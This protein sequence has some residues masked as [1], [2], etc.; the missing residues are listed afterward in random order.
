MAHRS[1]HRKFNPTE[2]WANKPYC[3][4]CK[5]KKV[6]YGQICGECEK[7]GGFNENATEINIGELN[8]KDLVAQFTAE[9]QER[10]EASERVVSLVGY[11]KDCAQAIMRSVALTDVTAGEISFIPLKPNALEQLANGQ[12][13]IKGKE[14]LDILY[15]V[16]AQASEFEVILGTLFVKGFKGNGNRT[17]KV[18]APLLYLK[19]DLEKTESDT[20]VFSLKED[21]TV[22]LNQSLIA[23][24]ASAEN[25]E[26]LEVRFQDLYSAVPEWPLTF[27]NVQK[28]FQGLN[29]YFPEIF[30]E[31]GTP[32][33]FIEFD[34]IEAEREGYK[35]CPA[36]C[37]ILAP[38]QEGEGT[39]VEEL[40]NIL[41][42]AKDKTALDFLLL[43][44]APTG[45]NP[46]SVIED[47]TRDGFTETVPAEDANWHSLFPFDL[48][49]TQKKIV[50][51][52][53][54]NNLTVVSG[55]PGTG[56]SYTIAAII[57]DHLL[58]GK[59]VLFVSRMDKAV[60][61]V[62]AWLEEFI[63][64]YSIARSGARK[65]QRALA[66]KLDTITS[67]NSPVIPYNKKQIDDATKEHEIAQ[68]KLTELEEEF[69]EAITNERS[70]TAV[71]DKVNDINARL[72]IE[73]KSDGLSI[74]KAKASRLKEKIK[75]ADALIRNKGFFIQT[76]WGEQ[77]IKSIRS[78]LGV[79]ENTTA[80]DLILMAE[81][82]EN[83]RVREEVEVEIAKFDAVD[84]IW[85]EIQ[86]LKIQLRKL[87]LDNLKARLLG[88]LHL[89]VHN[90]EKRVELKKFVK[91][92]R[93]ANIREKLAL[94][95][96]VKTDTLLAAFPCWASTTYHLS[97]ILPV[98]PGMFDLVIFDEAS[99]CD[100]ASAVP[101][102]YRANRVLIV[103]DPKQLNHVVFLGK[104]AEYSSFAKNKVPPDI[105]ANYRF[106]TNSLFDVAEN[107]VPQA[108][109]FMLDE[110]FRSDPHII[111]FSNK[112]FYKE[113]IRIMTHRPKMGLA[114]QETAIQLDYVKG[115]RTE[116]AANPL[117]IEAIFKHAKQ[118]IAQSPSE[119]PTTIGILSPF[120]DQVNAIT[121]AL[122][123]YLSLT[124]VERHKIVVGTAHSLQGDEK[125]VVILSL[126]L[127]PKFHHGTLNFL[128]KPNVF[129]VSITRAKKKLI[130][131]SSVTPEDLPNGLLKEF[132]LHAVRSTVNEIP[133]S[134]FDSKF[135]EQ[136]AQAL[137][138]SGMKVWPQYQAAG[139]YIDLVVGDGKNWVAV[140]C[141]GP[142]HFNME[143][144][145]NFYDVWRQGILER[146][147]WRFIRISNRDW[148]RDSDGQIQKIKQVLDTLNI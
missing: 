148:E 53:R 131:V 34:A 56:K 9:E 89:I 67:P 107:L 146:A 2:Y 70:W 101:A 46:V 57:L 36:H 22:H 44:K 145:Q 129:N 42:N 54:K 28:F 77:T 32:S 50:L 104:Q 94:L 137:E 63:G 144:R 100:L 113:Q 59:R 97:Q 132:F 6:K 115:K 23:S 16:R 5:K 35:L 121:K 69:T 66:E 86:S 33:Q 126:S 108:N 73:F 124:E 55:P 110:H 62:S 93:T 81:R 84:K 125:D 143:E 122:P 90:Y 128:E 21:D 7:A 48:S 130:A 105:Q 103:G 123:S 8:S 111:G 134:I 27:D 3:T 117:E 91:S 114:K 29:N 17:N 119:K 38:K 85:M 109:Y 136:V 31:N 138:H 68:K 65:A 25:D 92:L 140:E 135:E 30:K 24:V 47:Q 58:G 64:P 118:L 112:M 1:Y 102:L 13:E 19:V 37:L 49:D 43:E 78:Q 15:K 4:V 41:K 75:G 18:N 96:Q 71:H 40:S 141:D 10:S 87:A 98:Q 142:T 106:S 139:F 95:D 11:L 116:G 83:E 76:W 61:V 20:V 12:L 127:D 26:E 79:S 147:G 133:R 45:G 39:V 99:Q 74:K 51:N 14:A 88:N 60:D 82:I 80:Q 120:R 52:A 72:G